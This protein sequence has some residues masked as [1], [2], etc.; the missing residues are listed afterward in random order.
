MVGLNVHL[1]TRIQDWI[2]REENEDGKVSS[3][4][5]QVIMVL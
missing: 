4:N 1:G 2:S 3:E 5:F